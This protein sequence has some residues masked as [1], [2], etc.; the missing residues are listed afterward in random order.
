MTSRP[1]L[2]PRSTLLEQEEAAFCPLV[3]DGPLRLARHPPGADKPVQTLQIR[4][5]PGCLLRRLPVSRIVCHVSSL[6]AS[7]R[8]CPPMFSH[9]R[10]SAQGLS[11]GGRTPTS[12]PG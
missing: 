11:H 1:L 3:G 4:V 6:L 7:S 2:P 8:P 10:R 12:A 9:D 5:G